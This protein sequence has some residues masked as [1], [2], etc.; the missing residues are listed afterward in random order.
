MI[1]FY[2]ALLLLL[3]GGLIC[4]FVPHI[5]K[6]WINF[7]FSTAGF[8]FLFLP[9]LNVIIQNV[10]FSGTVYSNN[11]LGSFNLVVDPLSAF[12]VILISLVSCLAG[13]Y[14]IG[15]MKEYSGRNS[16]TGEHYFFQNI[17]AVAMLLVVTS[18]NAFFFLAA[19]ELMSVSSFFLVIFENE[20]EGVI[21]AGLHYLVSMHIGLILI[22]AGFIYLSTLSADFDFNSFKKAIE[23]NKVSADIL[24]LVFFTGFGIKAGFFPFHTWLPQAHPAAPAPVSGIMSGIMIKTGI[25]G[26]LR[27][28]SWIGNP[29]FFISYFVLAVSLCTGVQGVIYAI[30]QH[31]LKKLLAY[32]SMENIGIIGLGIGTGMLGLSYHNDL[33][34]VLGFTG[35][36]LHV[37][38][39]ALFKPLLFWGSGS[40]Y[41]QTHT[42]NIE[43]LGGLAKKMPYTAALFLTGSIAISGL[44]PLNGFISEFLIYLGLYKGLSAVNSLSSVVLVLSIAVLSLI[45]VL[46]LL[47]FT[48]AFGVVFLGSPRSESS[49]IAR[50]A[51]KTMLIPMFILGILIVM[52]G[53][54][55]G[56][57]YIFIRKVVSGTFRLADSGS[58]AYITN[59]FGSVSSILFVF[60]GSVFFMLLLRRL[61]LRKRKVSF[62][63]TWDC[64]YQAVNPRMQYTASSFAEPFIRLVGKVID[65]RTLLSPPEGLF[66]KEAMLDKEPR[67]LIETKIVS[68][69]VSL[70]NKF[71]NS[72]SWIQSG[73][74]QNYLI[75]GLIFL[76]LLIVWI[77]GARL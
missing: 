65:Y 15:Y 16:M 3:T 11:L 60:T 75:Y 73:K 44:P 64:G 51:P 58:G 66:P 71:L 33:M 42:R 69:A 5:I 2:L 28:L 27:I 14:S 13:L 9:C 37:L 38:N 47:C 76:L 17:L 54:F 30:A 55:P 6:G 72:F 10:N 12:F 24:F 53:F 70:L 7:I 59:L 49:L 31:D 41:E 63:K 18:Q 57:A 68:P 20:K 62:Q 4:I 25:Y 29:S 39:H 74:T 52:I 40:V 21:K 19:W 50:E 67:D 22:L 34:A 1:Y 56:Y 32:H 48:K 61:L 35:A 8:C 36:A 77:T 26:I 46:A 45:G 43:K 23:S